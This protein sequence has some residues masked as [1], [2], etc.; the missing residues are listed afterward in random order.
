MANPLYSQTLLDHVAHPDFNYKLDDASFSQ[1]GINPSCGDS[2]ELYLSVDA[3]KIIREASWEGQGCA[4]SKAS[5]DIM[6]DLICDKT[7]DEAKHMAKLFEAMILGEVEDEDELE[8]VLDE[9]LCL[10]DISHMPQRVRCA[11]LGWRTLE[12]AIEKMEQ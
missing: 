4:V 3:D 2:L 10:Q 7:L 6:C 5:S 9:A 8:E 1:H 12:A 11:E